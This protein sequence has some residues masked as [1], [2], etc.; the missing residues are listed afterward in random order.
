MDQALRLEVRAEE[1]I[2]KH[3][4]GAASSG[5]LFCREVTEPVAYVDTS[6]YCHEA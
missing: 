5:A 6:G 3:E 1:L 2:A 4:P